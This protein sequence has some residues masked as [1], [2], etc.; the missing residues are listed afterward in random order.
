MRLTSNNCQSRYSA[1]ILHP[2][3]SDACAAQKGG[4]GGGGEGE[5]EEDE[6]EEELEDDEESPLPDLM[7]LAYHFEQA[8]V[9]LNR[10]EMV[11]VELALKTLVNVSTAL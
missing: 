5:E 10:E 9:G 8:G 4:G 6:E 2:A 11:R 3:V 1:K 7:K